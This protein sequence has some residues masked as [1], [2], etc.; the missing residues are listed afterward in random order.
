M[1]GVSDNTIYRIE[2]RTKSDAAISEKT[3]I[4][5]CEKTG[6][7]PDWLFDFNSEFTD[8]AVCFRDSAM[9]DST[10]IVFTDSTEC[11]NGEA[12]SM[13][14]TDSNDFMDSTASNGG[15][16]DGATDGATDGKREGA[17]KAGAGERLKQLRAELGLSQAAF[18]NMI[19]IS[20]AHL[21]SIE[22]GRNRLMPATAKQIESRCEHGGAEWLLTGN[23]R[24]RHYPVGDE[25]IEWLR[26]HQKER[27][28]IWKKMKEME[29]FKDVDDV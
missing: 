15:E 14:S 26:N 23:E 11:F 12:D 20:R 5:I 16:A 3:L 18:S 10:A 28:R 21:A 29:G 22:T 7:D 17:E 25:M 19:G 13:D 8:F 2:G 27:E 9:G 4:T 24:N 1:C 6:V